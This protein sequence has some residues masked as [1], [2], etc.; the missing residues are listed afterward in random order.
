MTD[1]DY[2]TIRHLATRTGNHLAAECTAIVAELDRLRA[3]EQE[4]QQI[5]DAWLAT[6]NAGT[7]AECDA[8][9]DR[10][11]SLLDGAR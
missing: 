1:A 10:L 8:Q 4:H 7:E 5:V 9:W 11:F 3:V 6:G 2:P